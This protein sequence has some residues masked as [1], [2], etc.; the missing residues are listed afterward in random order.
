MSFREPYWEHPQASAR[1]ASAIRL[2][3]VIVAADGPILPTHRRRLLSTTVWKMTEAD[4]KHNLRYRSKAALDATS[5]SDVRHEH[6]IPRGVLVQRMM[7]EPHRVAEILSE[8]VACLVTKE[9]H[10]RLGPG[11][12]WDRYRLAGIEVVDMLDGST[13]DGNVSR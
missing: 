10:L 3:E 1:R 2:A 6:V 13:V 5:R 8:A 7:D 4:D 9:E 11:T 12:G